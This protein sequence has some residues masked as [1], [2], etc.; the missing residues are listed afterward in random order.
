[1]VQSGFVMLLVGL[2]LMAFFTLM[3]MWYVPKVLAP[4]EHEQDDEDERTDGGTAHF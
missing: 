2:V 3:T 4:S 1:M